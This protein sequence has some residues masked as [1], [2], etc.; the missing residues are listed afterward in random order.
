MLAFYR[1]C[2][3]GGSRGTYSPRVGCDASRPLFNVLGNATTTRLPRMMRS[4]N[5]YNL[6]EKL[7]QASWAEFAMRSR[8]E[9][10]K[11]WDYTLYR[12]GRRFDTRR[13]SSQRQSQSAQFFFSRVDLTA[14]CEELRRRFPQRAK[15][16]QESAEQICAHHFNLLGYE[17]LDYGPQIDW[18]ADVVHSK[19]APLKAWFKIR[20]L[21]F[22]EVGDSKITWELSRHQ[23]LVTLA[24]AYLLT[25]ES[26]YV[27]ELFHL[28]YDWQKKN[29]YPIGIHWASSLELAFRS[30]SWIWVHHLLQASPAMPASFPNDLT[31]AL[32]LHGR[33]IETYLSTYFSPNTHLLGEAVALFFLGTLYPGMHS[34]DRWKTMGWSIIQEQANRQVLD[35]G[36][37]FERSLHYHVYAL[38]FFLHARILAA[39]NQMPIAPQ[40]DETIVKMLETLC[41]LSQA[42][43]LPHFGDDDGGR[44]FDPARNRVEHLVDPLCAGA[45]VFRRGDFKAAGTL[46]EETIWLLGKE[47]MARLDSLPETNSK[48][49]AVL[50]ASGIY[51]MADRGATKQQLIIDAGS[52]GTGRGGHAHADALSVQLSIGGR[53]FLSDP[54]TFSYVSAEMDRNVMRGTGAH[55]TLRIDGLNQAES[56]GPFG[57]RTFPRVSVER[58]QNGQTFDLLVANQTAHH[59]LSKAPLHQRTIFYLKPRFWFV[60]DVVTGAREHEMDLFWHFPPGL[61]ISRTVFPGSFIVSGAGGEPSL[62]LLTAEDQESQNRIEEDCWSPSYGRVMPSRTLRISKHSPLPSEFAT[63]LVPLIS[64]AADC[65]RLTRVDF[66]TDDPNFHGYAYSADGELH[67]FLFADSGIKWNTGPWSSNARFFYCATSSTGELLHWIISQGSFVEMD[68][69]SLFRQDEIVDWGEWRSPSGITVGG[70]ENRPASLHQE[71]SREAEKVLLHSTA[72]KAPK[73][74]NR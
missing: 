59:G 29:P 34:A 69:H 19:R 73:A 8:Q 3:Q 28:W 43:S 62:A 14:I 12:L 2:R 37:H 5:R 61:L 15:E 47:G 72:E 1:R 26:R 65:G 39:V 17:A 27:E 42:G 66:D 49:A 54:G 51:V 35:D 20:Y 36:V 9:L 58:W 24:K 55:N 10:A 48:T 60:R 40:F 4:R 74:G 22:E 38:D 67:Y 23:H 70:R 45:I 41:T 46:S 21:D 31:A 30:L 44:V 7:R 57:W 18:H 56:D 6:P 33:H 50:P 13:L 52:L 11:R 16:I 63:I 53:E 32:E 25:Q 68:G 71:A 64:P